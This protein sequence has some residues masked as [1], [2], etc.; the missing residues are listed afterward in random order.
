MAT[1]KIS[2]LIFF[3]ILFAYSFYRFIGQSLAPGF[4]E[5]NSY[6]LL[7]L[8]TGLISLGFFSLKAKKNRILIA[9]LLI[10]LCTSTFTYFLN[11]SFVSIVTHL[12]GLREILILFSATIFI[13]NVTDS[14]F[15]AYFHSYFMKFLYFFLLCQIP[16]CI[17]QYLQFGAGDRVG[18]GFGPGGSGT[19]T[20]IVFIGVFFILLN[21]SKNKFS[22]V[23]L[24]RYLLVLP[25][26][27]PTFFNE[28]KITFVLFVL[29]FILLTKFNLRSLP[30]LILTF[31]IAAG[32]I[33]SFSQVYY[34]T[35][36]QQK[37]ILKN[38]A[39][40][41]SVEEI[42]N[43]RFLENYLLNPNTLNT[44][45]SRITKIEIAFDLILENRLHL[46]F[47]KG[48]GIFKGGNTVKSSQFAK[49]ND[50]LLG[51]TVPYLFFLILQGGIVNTFLILLLI[52]HPFKSFFKE[53]LP[54]LIKRDGYFL[55]SI[56]LLILFYNAAFREGAFVMIFLYMAWYSSHYSRS[57]SFH[58]TST[59]QM[60]S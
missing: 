35:V 29:L 18:G 22:G 57:I 47:G 46:L 44:D 40:R 6:L 4:P 14:N 27:T 10:F 48:F 37:H 33:F 7:I 36:K 13:V 50:W 53:H 21:H 16:I 39:R 38:D 12:N 41:S 55:I 31:V 25:F 1:K 17:Y 58:A 42:F 52:I 60:S 3:S 28:T 51:G 32:I 23:P 9:I 54:F 8:D 26:L 15:S 59:K 49:E 2:I 20:L 30:K 24:S 45:V 43:Q 34:L 19:L 11:D 56:F 5:V